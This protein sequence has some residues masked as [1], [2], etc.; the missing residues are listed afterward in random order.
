MRPSFCVV[1]IGICAL[2]GACFP[3]KRPTGVRD[4]FA[5]LGN[6][7]SPILRNFD[8]KLVAKVRPA[9]PQ[10][11]AP[12]HQTAAEP[13]QRSTPEPRQR[14]TPEPTRTEPTMKIDR[15]DASRPT[16]F[17]LRGQTH[18]GQDLCETHSTSDACNSRCTSMLRA[19]AFHKPEPS[20]PKSCSCLEMDGGSC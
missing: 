10:A 19:N 11:E 6:Q 4:R 8:V 3:S 7:I 2:A 20:M 5:A 14:P 12:P 1:V 13:M 17:V 9:P 18:G 16:V 15:V